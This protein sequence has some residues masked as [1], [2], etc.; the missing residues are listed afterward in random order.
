MA[1]AHKMYLIRWMYCNSFKAQLWYITTPSAIIINAAVLFFFVT[2]LV[3]GRMLSEAP[4][5]FLKIVLAKL[6]SGARQTRWS[7]HAK[8]GR[9]WTKSWELGRWAMLAGVRLALSRL[10]WRSTRLSWSW[11]R[12]S[13]AGHVCLELEAF[14]WFRCTVRRV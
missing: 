11:M 2:G 5:R 7:A 9:R 8:R 12:L 3:P 10:S 13:C 14:S 1:K 4:A 6:G